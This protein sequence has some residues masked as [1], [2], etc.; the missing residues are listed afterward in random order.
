MTHKAGA[1]HTVE[2]AVGKRRSNRVYT[3]AVVGR[4]NYD[5]SI[6]MALPDA[7]SWAKDNFDYYKRV[8]SL[9]VGD[10]YW[11]GLKVDEDQLEHA[12][13]FIEKYGTDREDA[14]FKRMGE[15][16]LERRTAKERAPKDPTVLMW[17]QS[18]VN[19][20]RAAGTWIKRGYLDVHVLPVTR[21]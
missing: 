15:L 18:E 11:P 7:L 16:L 3:L 12:K 10:E 8:A 17:S 19:A 2:G 9:K 13:A 4:R 5:R 21:R 20:R 6:E 14:V 1:L